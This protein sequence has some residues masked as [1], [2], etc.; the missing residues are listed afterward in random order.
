MLLGTQVA[1]AT[2]LTV[3]AYIELSL[4]RL[5]LAKDTWERE[6]QAPSGDAE[7]ALYQQYGTTVM[8]YYAFAGAHRQEIEGYLG[9]HPEMQAQ[10]DSLSERLHELIE[11]TERR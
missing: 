9:A 11:Q 2:D 5:Q 7:E 3:A 8:A 4:A 10:I 1:H 6:Q